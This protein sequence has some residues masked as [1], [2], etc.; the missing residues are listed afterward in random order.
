MVSALAGRRGRRPE[1]RLAPN[2]PPAETEPLSRIPLRDA[3]RDAGGLA[4]AHCSISMEDLVA[5]GIAIAEPVT[6]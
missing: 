2:V 4:L 6:D 1:P 5:L 3:V